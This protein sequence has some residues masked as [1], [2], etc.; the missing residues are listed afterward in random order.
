MNI[1]EQLKNTSDYTKYVFNRFISSVEVH[2]IPS[3][4]LLKIFSTFG[5]IYKE[6]IYF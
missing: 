5:E 4:T 2:K 3:L 6:M 1:Y